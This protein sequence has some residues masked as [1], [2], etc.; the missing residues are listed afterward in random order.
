V[1]ALILWV[2]LTAG[3][4]AVGLGMAWV[5]LFALNAVL[6][7]FRR[8]DDGTLREFVPAAIAY[9]TWGLTSV[10]GAVLAWRWVRRRPSN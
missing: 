6:P 2:A 1:K 9:V 10:V 3:A 8:E 4:V 7:P 5:A